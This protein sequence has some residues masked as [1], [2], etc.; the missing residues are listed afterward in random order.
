MADELKQISSLPFSAAEETL[1]TFVDAARV[2]SVYG[3]PITYGDSVLIPAAEVL[4]VMGVGFGVGSGNEEG[5][6][7]HESG[8]GGG[9][10]G[11][12]RAFARPV[13]VVIAS[14]DGVRVE[15]I[16]DRTKIVLAAITAGGFMLAMVLRLIKPRQALRD[17]KQ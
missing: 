11:G 8:G 16:I 1:R 13:A 9:G 14:P 4:S 7:E 12:G 2:T 15:P 6:D 3:E 10:G 5:K 17:M